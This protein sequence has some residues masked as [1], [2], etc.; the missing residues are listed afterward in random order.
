MTLYHIGFVVWKIIAKCYA[1]YYVIDVHH[2]VV[3]FQNTCNK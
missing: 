1:R 3:N 2:A